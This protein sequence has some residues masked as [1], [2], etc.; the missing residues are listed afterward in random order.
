MEN[1]T[2]T[3][4]TKKKKRSER[5]PHHNLYTVFLILMMLLTGV[6]LVM[7]MLVDAFPPD[8]LTIIISVLGILLAVS[9]ALIFRKKRWMRILGL[10][11]AVLFIAVSS[12][13]I[14][15]M[16]NTYAM[17]NRITG[18]TE[19]TEASAG[20]VDVTQK[21]F[22]LYIT[23]IDQWNKDKG[24]DL[25]R[26]DVN[27]ILTV[28]PVTRKVL[29]TSIPR[30]AYVP[31]HRTGTMDKL[32]HTGIYGVDETLN[33]V[34]DWT[35]L[36]LNYYVKANFHACVHLVEAIGGI[37]IYNPVEFRSSLTKH[38]YP[39]GNIHLKGYGAL[40]YA[41][42]RKAF[43]GEDQLRVKNQLIVVEAILHKVL[44]STTLLTSYA[45]IMKV[46]GDEIS[47][48]MSTKEIQAL[49]KMQLADM[50]EWDIESQ[51]MSGEYGMAI[52]AS[53]DPSNEYQVLNVSDESFNKCLK[54]IDRVLNPTEED[55]QEA[56]IRK[57]ELAL[58]NK[59]DVFINFVKNLLH[60]GDADAGSGEAETEEGKE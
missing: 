60:K 19:Q 26:S 47:T 58:Q 51:R 55:L 44:S 31:L 42:E 28:N 59:R 8:L 43:E 11:F 50:S 36:D 10:M 33:T 6:F 24:L 41:R 38:L 27:M 3:K 2:N 32:T 54:G 14:Y 13:G 45:D 35:G 25:E 23:G 39:K 22:N 20:S 9:G 17:F 7:L 30:D 57:E 1:K 37:D 12:L 5:S 16:G 34:H 52:V 48:N 56:A 18:G 15:Y 46:L 40:Y 49:V 4:K 53:M 29:L 21:P